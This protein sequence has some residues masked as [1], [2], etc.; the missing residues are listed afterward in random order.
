MAATLPGSRYV[1]LPS[2]VNTK[3]LRL[4]AYFNALRVI[5]SFNLLYVYM[6]HIYA[7]LIGCMWC[8]YVYVV[9]L[10]VMK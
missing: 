2:R 5:P 8:M 1:I 10:Y 3:V 6:T 9:H 4:V 7:P